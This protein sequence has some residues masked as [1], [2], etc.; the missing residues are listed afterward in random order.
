MRKKMGIVVF[1]ILVSVAGILSMIFGARRAVGDPSGRRKAIW[2]GLLV[3]LLGLGLIVGGI[4]TTIRNPDQYF[5][6]RASDFGDACLVKKSHVAVWH[7]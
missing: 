4:V 6:S 3:L 1:G 2:T 7:N 5:G